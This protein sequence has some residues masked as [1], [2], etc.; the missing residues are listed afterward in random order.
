MNICYYISGHGYGH[1]TRVA[2][3][4]SAL[5]T[6]PS[7]RMN[8]CTKAP[9]H[10][11]PSSDR[12][13]FRNK[14]VDSSI[15]QPSPYEIDV[16]GTFSDLVQFIG[17]DSLNAWLIEEARFID[18]SKFDVILMDAPWIVGQ[19]QPFCRRTLTTILVT[20]FT[21]DL[22]F[23][24]LLQYLPRETRQKVVPLIDFVQ[25]SYEKTDYLVRLPGFI[26]FP[27][28]SKAR[29]KVVDAPLV[30]RAPRQSK[31][32]VMELL[33]I[34]VMYQ[35]HK[36]LLI[37]F[38]G[39]AVKSSSSSQSSLPEGWIALI[40][41]P[42]PD[43]RFFQFDPAI[44][45]PDLIDASDAILGKIGYGTVSECIGMGK[46][47]LYVSRTMFAEEP[48]LLRSMDELG[49]SHEISRIDFESGNWANAITTIM[50]KKSV[51]ESE[52]R[53]FGMGDGSIEIAKI[54]E[55]LVTQS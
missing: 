20:N 19:L 53:A 10:L 44:Y 36:L 46:P 15:L 24:D 16:E 33:H 1:A 11:F 38:G 52:G 55:D 29:T 13:T 26:D 25:E 5:L 9:H 32:V 39:F 51:S 49:V 43:P 34:P 3:V 50:K 22:I 21:F 12:L 31:D 48:Y 45:L 54:I 2:Q 17:N 18:A 42:H 27:F 35:K 14:E 40:S 23:Q 41:S 47:L 8:I 4:T 6:N 7:T 37:Q 30:Y 28:L